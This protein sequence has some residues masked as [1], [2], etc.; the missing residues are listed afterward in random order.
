MIRA[1]LVAAVAGFSW[2]YF[3]D[4]SIPGIPPRHTIPPLTE[5][6]LSARSDSNDAIFARQVVNRTH[7]GDKLTALQISGATL[8]SAHSAPRTT[9]TP[10]ETVKIA[11]EQSEEGISKAND[12]F[13]E[14]SGANVGAKVALNPANSAWRSVECLSDCR[15]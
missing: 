4:V 10:N 3:V 9:P 12:V 13:D 11:F 15:R 14:Y 2:P 1:V 8:D 5:I 7:K 6:G